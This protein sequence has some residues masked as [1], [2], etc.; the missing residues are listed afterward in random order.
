MPNRMV[1]NYDYYAFLAPPHHHPHHHLQIW[2]SAFEQSY[3]HSHMTLGSS[4]QH[5]KTV[6]HVGNNHHKYYGPTK[7]F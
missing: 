4:Y 7:K 5:H 3:S 6:Y 1:E 2:K